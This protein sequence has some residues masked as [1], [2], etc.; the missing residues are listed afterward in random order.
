MTEARDEILRRVATAVGRDQIDAETEA[1]LTQRLHRLARQLRPQWDDDTVE[2]F[3]A[4]LNAA[5]ASVAVV[6]SAAQVAAAVHAF[7]RQN[8]IPLSLTV[9][10]DARLDSYRWPDD[11]E[12]SRRNAIADDVT[13]VTAAEA[14]IVET[15]SL[16]LRSSPTSPTGMNFL[17]ENHVVILRRE[18]LVQNLEDGWTCALESGNSIPRTVN[19]ISGPSKTADI[20]QTIEYGAHGPRRLHVVLLAQA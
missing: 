8:D 20:E 7:L 2:R 4:K 17:P 19:F 11:I 6:E 1:R 3:V 10:P 9:A 13:S 14:G 16:V 18:Q 12:V 15:G 5:A